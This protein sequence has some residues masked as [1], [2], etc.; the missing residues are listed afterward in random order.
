MSL[1]LNSKVWKYQDTVSEEAILRFK[2]DLNIHPTLLKLLLHRGVD[3]YEKAKLFF[4]PSLSEIHDPYLMKDMHMAVNRIDRAINEGQ[5]IMVY[6][7]YDVDGTTAVALMYHFLSRYY[8]EVIYYIPDRYKEGYGVSYQGI[9]FASELSC[10][11]IIALDC[12]IKAIEKV[13]Y[14]KEKGIDFIICDHHKPGDQLPQAVAVLDP[15]RIDC[16]YPF[17]ELSGCG[18]GFKLVQAL[19]QHWDREQDEAYR[20]LDI[21]AI[22]ISADM[23]SLVEENRILCS[24]GLKSIASS[25]KPGIHSLLKTSKIR[26]EVS[27]GDIGFKIGPRIN[28]AGR[29]DHG[30]KAVELL[31][32]EDGDFTDFGSEEMDVAN[33]N[34]KEEQLK[35]LNEAIDQIESWGNIEDLKSIVVY[36]ENWHK[37]ILGIVASK[38]VDIYYKPTVVLTKSGEKVAGSARSVKEFSI[39]DALDLSSEHLIQFGGHMYAAGMTLKEENV[40][41]FRQKLEEVVIDKIKP[42]QCFPEIEIESEIKLGDITP[43]F[44]KI[45]KD[46]GPF[47]QDNPSPIFSAE[48]V[49]DTGGARIVGDNHL[50]LSLNDGSSKESIAAIGFNLGHFTQGFVNGDKFKIAFCIEENSFRNR[51]TIQLNIKDIKLV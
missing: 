4:R 49:F 48:G 26:G 46:M 38:L 24:L 16:T 30:K 8:S 34:R 3:T 43:A 40:F 31:V 20:Y 32:S 50:K 45:L 29:M 27:T 41:L 21:L 12:G 35:T 13:D 22:S 33:E 36:Q 47:G 51:K 44:Y 17:K 10:D 25:Q 23:V 15:K 14:A 11:L 42:E 1:S 28:A 5:K 39:Y 18:V 6:G 9:D 2:Q 37:G 7:D 19:L